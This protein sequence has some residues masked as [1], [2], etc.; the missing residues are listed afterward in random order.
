MYTVHMYVY[1]CTVYK[2][3]Y[4]CTVY[5]HDFF[6]TLILVQ[7]FFQKNSLNF[8]PALQCV[9]LLWQYVGPENLGFHEKKNFSSKFGN[10]F[11]GKTQL[12][13]WP[14]FWK[15]VLFRIRFWS[16]WASLVFGKIGKN[17]QQFVQHKAFVRQIFGPVSVKKCKCGYGPDTCVK[18]KP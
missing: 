5:T 18:K 13:R 3:V 9:V 15:Y 11:A 14:F 8:S 1:Y 7:L 17:F 12:F 16:F 6:A 10:T 4:Y 2:H